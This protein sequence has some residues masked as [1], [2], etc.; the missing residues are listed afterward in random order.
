[1]ACFYREHPTEAVAEIHVLGRVTSHDMDE[2]IPKFD[3]FIERHGKVRIIEVIE[4]FEG[5]DHSAM[6]DG[7]IFDLHHIRDVTHAAIVSDINWIGMITRAAGKVMPITIRVF[8]LDQIDRA[9][10]WAGQAGDANLN[11]PT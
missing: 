6:L 8:P 3:A 2:I 9:R 11:S 1:M 7:V 4:K 10:E 5:F